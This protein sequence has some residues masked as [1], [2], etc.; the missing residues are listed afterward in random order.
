M[1]RIKQGGKVT[2]EDKLHTITIFHW[3]KKERGWCEQQRYFYK[4]SGHSSEE[5]QQRLL[6]A[7]KSWDISLTLI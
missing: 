2:N 4:I 3:L 7:S 5:A 1:E 6:W